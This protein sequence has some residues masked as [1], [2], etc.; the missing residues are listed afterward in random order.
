MLKVKRIA[1]FP[2]SPNHATASECIVNLLNF[3]SHFNEIKV[4]RSTTI[5]KV[6]ANYIHLIFRVYVHVHVIIIKHNLK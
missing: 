5:F 2:S 3:I 6:Y 4:K 1:K